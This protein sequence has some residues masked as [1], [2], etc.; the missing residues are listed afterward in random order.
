MTNH[1]RVCPKSSEKFLFACLFVYF[2]PHEQFVSYLAAVTIA[3]DWAANLDLCLAL[4][5]FSS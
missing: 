5:A 2:E 4:I 1:T 3:G